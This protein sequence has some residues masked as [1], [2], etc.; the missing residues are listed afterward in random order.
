MRTY[1]VVVS[2]FEPFNKETANASGEVAKRLESEEAIARIQEICGDAISV[3]S[4]L[5]PLSFDQAWPTLLRTINEVKPDIIVAIGMKS[6]ARGVNLERC[7]INIIDADK[8][9]A[10]NVQPR[11]VAVAADGPA[12]FWTKL[13]LRSILQTFAEG[14]IIPASLSSDAG[15][16]VCNALFYQ[17]MDWCSHQPDVLAGFV[18]LPTINETDRTQNG[19]PLKQMVEAGIQV[20]AQTARYWTQTNIQEQLVRQ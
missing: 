19:L 5:L 11:K 13:P 17:L 6:H 18:S 8:P 12:A 9:D 3:T 10:F 4:Q 20:I 16:Y 1:K 2:G 15:T 7:A 14:E